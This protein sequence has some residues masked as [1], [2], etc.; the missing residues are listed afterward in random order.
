MKKSNL[1]AAPSKAPRHAK[2]HPDFP[3]GVHPSGRWCKRVRGVLRYFGKIQ[4]DE[5]GQAAL[6]EWLRVKDDLLAGRTP[7]P[8]DD[9]RLT[10]RELANKFLTY[11]TH[12]VRTAELC[13]RSFN[14]YQDSCERMI[15]V[16]G[17]NAV[18]EEIRSDDLLRLRESLAKCRKSVAGLTSEMGRCQVILNFAYKQALIDRPV[19]FGESFKKPSKAAHRRAK[20]QLELVRGKQLFSAAEIGT[21]TK[22]A[23]V[24]LRAMILLAINAGF[25]N[26]DCGRLVLEAVN[27]DTGW[28]DFPRPKTGIARRV[29]LWPETA[30]AI[31][32]SLA[33]RRTPKSPEHAS[34]VFVT[35]ALLPWHKDDTTCNPISQAFRK[36]LNAA[37]LYRKG[38]GFYTL[39]H[40]FE[41]V[42]GATRD[43][44][45]VN[46]V[47]GHVDDTMAA[48]YREEVGDDRLRAVADHVRGW[49][50]APQAD[51]TPADTSD[52]SGG[53]I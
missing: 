20:S 9:Q 52:G 27:L 35:R 45:A 43:Q 40:T 37:G 38:I 49:L 32:A 22:L 23:D 19:R 3:L 2:P 34:L 41:T 46:V 15:R 44:V 25:G 16:L 53:G 6:A 17:S 21:L 48:T 26:A 28:I 39:R 24:H 18:V 10:V 5:Q 36:V 4:G 14:D 51:T 29:P 1:S 12:K 31:R 33:E 42:A 50:F 7:R 11:N 8:R 30:A 13:Q 47:M